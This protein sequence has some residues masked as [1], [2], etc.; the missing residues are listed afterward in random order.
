MKNEERKL[1]K[2]LDTSSRNREFTDIVYSGY[3]EDAEETWN[4]IKETRNVFLP[5]DSEYNIFFGEVHGHTNLSD[6]RPT[7]DEYFTSIRDRAKLDFAAVSDHEHGGVAKPELWDGG[8][9]MTKEA[10]KKYY[11]PH[12]FTTILAYEKDAYPWYNNC[13]VYYNSHDGEMLRGVQD[14]EMTRKEL[15]EYLARDDIFLA[16]HDTTEIHYA[17]D[18]LTMELEDMTPL[19]QVYSRYNYSERFDP[20]LSTVDIE[21][22]HWLD[23]LNRGAKMGCISGSDDHNGN[24]GLILPDKGYPRSFPG[25]TA[26]LAKE[27]TLPAIFE[28]LKARR[29][30]ALMGGKIIV[31]FRINGHYM[32]EEIE[33]EGDRTIYY[34]VEADERIDFVTLVKNGRDY[35]KLKKSTELMFDYRVENDTDYYYLRVRLKDGRIAWTSPI[36]INSNKEGNDEK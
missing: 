31:D 20:E 7:L 35:V 27:N 19:M 11:E 3:H 34:K 26:V 33:D 10:V 25:I 17:V 32:G 23:A 5:P 12:K 8:W 18:F 30:Y 22:G 36:W 9:E 29:C 4:K 28:A 24:N 6:G 14:G 15:R 13:I 1:A 16:P 21:G 2:R